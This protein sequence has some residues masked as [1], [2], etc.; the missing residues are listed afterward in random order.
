MPALQRAIPP[1][2]ITPIIDPNGPRE[3]PILVKNINEMG[4]FS[5]ELNTFIKV[6]KGNKS[7]RFTGL[8]LNTKSVN[9]WIDNKN[10]WF[11]EYIL[12]TGRPIPDF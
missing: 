7:S 12:L 3:K 2:A 11:G 5:L 1:I 10:Y 9:D 8:N 6:F 4:N